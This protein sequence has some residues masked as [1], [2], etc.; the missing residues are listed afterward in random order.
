MKNLSHNYQ[1]N[2]GRQI[3]PASQTHYEILSL[4]H[5]SA[6]ALSH[7]ASHPVLWIS[8]RPPQ[9]VLGIL[10]KHL[11]GAWYEA[12][13]IIVALEGQRFIHQA[14]PAP[15]ADIHAVLRSVLESH[16]NGTVSLPISGRLQSLELDSFSA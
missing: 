13:H 8:S 14:P 11:Q 7:A 1:R 16:L 9:Q 12:P 2:P 6:V 3:R 4:D 15:I 5:P 10:G